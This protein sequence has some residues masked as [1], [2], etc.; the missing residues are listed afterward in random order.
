MYPMILIASPYLRRLV[1]LAGLACVDFVTIF[2]DVTPHR[3]QRR[4][5]PDILAKGGTTT[6]VVG[7]EVVEQYGGRVVTTGRFLERST[8]ELVH[9]IRQTVG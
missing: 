5:Q 9:R 8:T 3:V 1:D 4:L 7:R 2:D 6:E